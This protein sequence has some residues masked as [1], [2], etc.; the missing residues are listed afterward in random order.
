MCQGKNM[1][2]RERENSRQNQ[3]CIDSDCAELLVE[4]RAAISSWF[5]WIPVDKTP[6][7]PEVL[8]PHCPGAT[9]SPHGLRYH[10]EEKQG[11]RRKVS[12]SSTYP[13]ETEVSPNGERFNYLLLARS[14]HLSPTSPEEMH[15]LRIK[16]RSVSEYKEKLSLY[17]TLLLLTD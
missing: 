1:F 3:L 2:V 5:Q 6:P 9:E 15:R 14:P 4:I 8:L 13:K 16:L 7:R 12:K 11:K 17:S 10:L